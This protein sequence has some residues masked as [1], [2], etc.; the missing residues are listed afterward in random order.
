M[1]IV[2]LLALEAQCVSRDFQKVATLGAIVGK[3]MKVIARD[4]KRLRK[5]RRINTDQSTFYVVEL[6]L[7]LS[8]G[9]G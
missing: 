4:A 2:Q 6:E 7:L 3:E 9:G 8:F 5:G 1:E